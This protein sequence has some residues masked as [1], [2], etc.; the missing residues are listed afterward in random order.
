MNGS[1]FLLNLTQL[2]E[3]YCQPHNGPGEQ[4]LDMGPT[5]IDYSDRIRLDLYLQT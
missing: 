2:A 4:W 5:N 1:K 3:E